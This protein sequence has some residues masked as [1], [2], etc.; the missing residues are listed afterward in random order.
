V[1]KGVPVAATRARRP[2]DVGLAS[3][4]VPAVL[5]SLA[6]HG[7]VALVLFAFGPYPSSARFQD[8][9]V[10]LRMVERARIPVLPSAQAEATGFGRELS[11]EPTPPRVTPPALPSR[12]PAERRSP[13]TPPQADPAETAR[14][15][16][17]VT[18]RDAP[19][20]ATA[21]APVPDGPGLP[22]SAGAPT[23]DHPESAS[24]PA[25]VSYGNPSPA[26]ARS[27]GT[28]EADR[29]GGSGPGADA[30]GSGTGRGTPDG[31]GRGNDPARTTGVEGLPDQ[32]M[33]YGL[34][35]RQRL[36]G[37][38]RYPETARRSGRDGTVVLRLHVDADG[39]VAT[40]SV[41]SPSNWPDLDRAALAAVDR[42]GSLPPPPGG[43]I[44][45]VVPVRFSLRRP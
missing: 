20:V 38:R 19:A 3:R 30:P 8:A 15:A 40:T 36:E 7:T 28:A 39:H 27:G 33:R 42:L 14:E 31:A 16:P 6:F 2:K 1:G 9:Q 23:L 21:Q 5:V 24:A 10:P 17:P 4:L 29:G 43:P 44:E 35:V 13:D 45:V 41:E 12:R 11:P 25:R 32:R 34:G 18:E 26:P 22:V 37:A